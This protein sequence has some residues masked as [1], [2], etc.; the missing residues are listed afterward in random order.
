MVTPPVKWHT[1]LLQRDLW[2]LEKHCSL[3]PLLISCLKHTGQKREKTTPKDGYDYMGSLLQWQL[4]SIQFAFRRIFHSMLIGRAGKWVLAKKT[5]HIKCICTWESCKYVLGA[6]RNQSTKTISGICY[7]SAACAAHS[8]PRS[9]LLTPW[10]F[11]YLFFL[12]ERF[13]LIWGTY[14]FFL[15]KCVAVMWHHSQW[16]Q[17]KVW[18]AFMNLGSQLQGQ[19]NA[20]S[21]LKIRYRQWDEAHTKKEM[22]R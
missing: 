5:E 20:Q 14:I 16:I 1:A 18:W 17:R 11:R 21:F 12:L 13:S 7:P 10:T 4:W 8:S 22:F 2:Q 3:S 19:E 9:Q 6:N 15:I